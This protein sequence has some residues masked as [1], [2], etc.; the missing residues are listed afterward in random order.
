MELRLYNTLTRH[1]DKFVSL[2][3][4]KVS[5]Y[6]CGPT[7]YNFAHI[8]NLRSYI[9]ADLLRRML[10]YND[11]TV[12][13]VMNVTDVGH[14]TSDSDAGDDKMEREARETG[15]DIW[16]LA[17]YFEGV[18]F[19][20]LEKLNIEAPVVKCRATEHIA[21]M[22]S[23]V[24]KLVERGHAYETQQAVYFD[25]ATFPTYTELTRQSLEDKL[26]AA[27]DEVQED[28][29]KRNPADFALWFK[30]IGRFANHIMRWESPWGVGFPGWHIECSAMSMKYLGETLD[31]H[32]GG[33]DHIW[34][35][36]PNEIA[37]SEGATGKKFV[38]YWLHGAFLVVGDLSKNAQQTDEERRMGKSEGNFLR[39]QTLIDMGYDPLAY[40]YACLMAHYRTKLKFTWESMDAAASGYSSIKEFVTRA[41]QIGGEEQPWVADYRERF[42]AAISDD[43]NMPM[44]MAVV[45][46][47]I[48][49]AEG[50]K[51]YGVINALYDFDRVLALN[52][53]KSAEAA[54]SVDSDVEALIKE[55]E[56]A[57]A[58][59]NWARADEIRKI[60]S[61]QGVTLEDTAQGTIWHKG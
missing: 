10:E 53:K 13:H 24:E 49:E 39:L 27:R 7:V 5:L 51:E 23:L 55:R 31:I 30:A 43:L 25:L 11:Y 42:K 59:K 36:H 12:N 6:T 40:R 19:E 37:Q 47:L 50:R 35:H 38:K 14:L 61:Q 2:E 1:K 17:R 26:T 32:T 21:E 3:P 22:I 20:D 46:E 44:A 15:K 52:L 41:H 8:G 28:P 56:Q 4:G 9:F 48:R 60:L 57:R 18:F 33:E 58:D 54:T 34:V 16:E 45:Y 29:E